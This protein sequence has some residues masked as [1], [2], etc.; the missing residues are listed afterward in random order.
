MK[1]F[2]LIPMGECFEYQGE[3]YSKSGPLTAINLANNRQRMIPRSAVVRPLQA[4]QPAQQEVPK[5]E[6]QML[7][8][9]RV[10]EAFE[11]YH[12]GCLEWL[13]LIETSDAALAARIRDAMT[14]ARQR[15]L[16]ELTGT[17]H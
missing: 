4:D 9:E 1:R 2:T 8:A 6:Q 15:F 11:Q 7:P 10:T 13:G 16:S 5:Q 17:G 12:H 14:S 3:R